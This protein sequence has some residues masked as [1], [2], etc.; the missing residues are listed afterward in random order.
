MTANRKPDRRTQRTRR[1]QSGALADLIKEK[2]FEDITV[3]SVIDP[4]GVGRS[5]F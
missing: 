2:R 5:A 1:Q 4:A 3:Q